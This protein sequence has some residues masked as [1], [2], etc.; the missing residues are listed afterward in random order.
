[1]SDEILTYEQRE[2]EVHE[3]RKLDISTVVKHREVMEMQGAVWNE[4]IANQNNVQNANVKKHLQL[5]E[6]EI[7]ALERIAV[8]LE[9]LH[10]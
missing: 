3:L 7:S 9:K 2:K 8:A 6:R 1:M 10:A 5:V 4:M